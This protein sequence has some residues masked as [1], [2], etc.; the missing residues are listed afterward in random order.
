MLF[1][2]VRSWPVAVVN[3]LLKGNFSVEKEKVT[4]IKM[5]VFNFAIINGV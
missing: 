3:D 5:R 1:S 2:N 4:N